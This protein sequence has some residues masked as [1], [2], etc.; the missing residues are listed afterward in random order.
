MPLPL[1]RVHYRRAKPADM[2]GCARVFV[3]AAASLSQGTGGQLMTLRPSDM[4]PVFSHIRQTDPGGFQVAEM[5]D[6]VVGYASVIARGSTDFLT[7]FWVFPALK[8]KGLG[9]PLLQRAFAGVSPQRGDVR[10]V[11]ASVDP[12]AQHL[13]LSFGMLPRTMIYSMH[14]EPAKLPAKPRNAVELEPVSEPGRASREA[15]ALCGRYDRELRG[16]RR[17]ADIEF[18]TKARKA[19]VFRAKAGGREVGYLVVAPTGQV[20]PGGAS[21]ERWMAGLA[22]AGLRQA[23][24][25]SDKELVLVIPGTN[26]GAVEMALAARMHN[27]FPG[28]WMSQ[29]SILANERY[30]PANGILW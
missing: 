13:Y 11:Y 23:R 12:R 7:Q 3:R 27:R 24:R 2:L 10:C 15:L 19:T 1:G 4:V 26:R 18:T 29:R 28:T 5:D 9:R 16:A 25:M 22:W 8:G 17:D 6:R 14:G 21:H 30:L 20:G